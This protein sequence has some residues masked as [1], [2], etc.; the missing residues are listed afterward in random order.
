MWQQE[1]QTDNSIDG[2][3]AEHQLDLWAQE[4]QAHVQNLSHITEIIMR[5]ESW[6]NVQMLLPLLAQL[7][8]DQR[9]L[10]WVAPPKLLPKAQ[11]KAAGFD[12]NKIIL[13]KPDAQHDT[14]SLA[15]QA[16]KSGTCHAV[17]SWFG[18]L[19]DDQLNDLA[20]AAELGNSRAFL[21][22]HQ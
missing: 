2:I 3:L 11:L 9:W 14:M 5:G 22:R 20:Q 21:I 15:H 16:L 1:Q 17:I 18:A 6:N 4:D 7:S 10:A 13:L 12:L 19:A 8:H